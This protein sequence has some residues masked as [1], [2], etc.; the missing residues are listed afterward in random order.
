[1][2]DTHASIGMMIVDRE[3]QSRGLGRFVVA[4]ASRLTMQAT[5]PRDDAASGHASSL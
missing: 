3:H 2:G 1:M 5:V 4:V